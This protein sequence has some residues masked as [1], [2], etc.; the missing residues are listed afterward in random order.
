MNKL[1]ALILII[2]VIIWAFYSY[3][4]F[5]EQQKEIQKLIKLSQEIIKNDKRLLDNADFYMT[6][7]KKQ[8]NQ[9]DRI[10]W[11][12]SKIASQLEIDLITVEIIK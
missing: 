8:S 11:N 4:S 9:M 3:N 2:W 12:I 10:E 5:K 6:S 7:I 1:V